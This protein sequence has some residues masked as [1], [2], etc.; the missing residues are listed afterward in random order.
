MRLFLRHSP[1]CIERLLDKCLVSGSCSEQVQ[2]RV[3]L[4]FGMFF[5]IPLVELEDRCR[6]FSVLELLLEYKKE[7]FLSHP[8]FETYLKLKWFGTWKIYV[9]ILLLYLAFLVSVI[10]YSITR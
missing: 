1:E 5:P 7:R 8:L 10:G 6:D 3:I 9:I 4:D 2:G